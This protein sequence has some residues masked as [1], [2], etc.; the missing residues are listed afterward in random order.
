MSKPDFDRR[1]YELVE[2]AIAWVR[3]AIDSISDDEKVGQQL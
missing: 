2:E 3:S 1:P